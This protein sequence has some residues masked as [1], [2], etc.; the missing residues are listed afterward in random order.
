MDAEAADLPLGGGDVRQDRGRR[1]E[2]DL[3]R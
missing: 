3:E 2:P 1:R